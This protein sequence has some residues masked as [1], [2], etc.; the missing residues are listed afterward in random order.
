[1]VLAQ[2]TPASEKRISPPPSGQG[3]LREKWVG[4]RWRDPELSQENREALDVAALR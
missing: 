4:R 2:M 1:M 3:R